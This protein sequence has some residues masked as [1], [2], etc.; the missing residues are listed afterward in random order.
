MKKESTVDS[1]F[2]ES[3]ATP[4]LELTAEEAA[5]PPDPPTPAEVEAAKEEL[6]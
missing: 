6:F 2:A 1:L 3:T 5:M 4:S